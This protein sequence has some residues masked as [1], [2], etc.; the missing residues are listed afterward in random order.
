MSLPSIE[1]FL[2]APLQTRK[3]RDSLVGEMNLHNLLNTNR[4]GS[5][6]GHRNMQYE[7]PMP[8]GLSHDMNGA[9]H[10]QQNLFVPNGNN[11]IKSETGS[12]RGVS[13]HTSDHSSRY[14]SQ[15]PQNSNLAYQMQSQ[16]ANGMRYPS[17]QL[18]QQNGMAPMLQQHSYQP[19]TAS[20]TPYQPQAQLGA[21][22]QQQ[23]QDASSMDGG[24]Q[25]SAPTGLPK[26][27]A[28]NTC[29]K[30][31]ARRSDLARHGT[32]DHISKY[33]SS[34]ADIMQNEFTAECGLMPA[35]TLAATSSSSSG[36]P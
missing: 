14:S 20:D 33:W 31:F 9:P 2:L 11:R 12:E 13:P 6:T 16:L 8:V 28:C 22:Q 26:A 23:G 15:T 25:G 27:F 10:Y 17:P 24:R 21:V 4:S 7:V 30:G 32:L 36:Q 5:A 19:H 29:Q 18:A 34:D 1:H 35:T 3:R